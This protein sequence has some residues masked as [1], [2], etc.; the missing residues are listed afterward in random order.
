MKVS[1]IEFVLSLPTDNLLEGELKYRRCLLKMMHNQD[2]D[3]TAYYF[4]HDGKLVG[5][6][7]SSTPSAKVS[8]LLDRLVDGGPTF[9]WGAGLFSWYF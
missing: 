2:F 5:K 3:K 4:F 7:K 9:V 1:A 8:E 6:S